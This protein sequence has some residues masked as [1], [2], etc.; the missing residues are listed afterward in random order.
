MGEKEVKKKK[1]FYK[2]WWFWCCISL[3]LIVCIF[4]YIYYL[5]NNKTIVDDTNLNKKVTLGR[6][7]FYIDD[8]WETKE[9]SEGNTIYEY[10]YPNEDTMLMVQYDVDEIYEDSS[11]IN[12]F[13]DGYVSGLEQESENITK[14]TK[15][16][17]DIDCGIARCY[18]GDY[19]TVHY[20]IVNDNEFYVFCFG[21]KNKIHE[22]NTELVENIIEKAEIEIETEEE[23][24][25]KL[26]KEAEEKE[27][28]EKAEKQRKQE[29][30]KQFKK[31][32]EEYTFEQLARNPD[33]VRDKKVKVTGEVIQ[34]SEGIY[35][36]GLRVNI[37][38]NEYDWYED[39]I[40]VTYVPEE[41]KDKIL[42]DD[43]ITVWGTAEGEYSYTSV[44]GATVTLPYISAEYLE[45]E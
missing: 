9:E 18:I 39:T 20:I 35:T 28:K 45:I 31:E 26:Q 4:I 34:V 15:K 6:L 41:G 16:I 10:Y 29:K 33:K 42:E 19:E 25:E 17:K 27:Q 36:N 13:L 32:C 1:N 22:Q 30:E 23:K 7:S 21:Q 40:Y 11:D 5:S 24:Q 38:K 14:T 37:T 2:K 43:I 8:S 12:E 44:M 3:L